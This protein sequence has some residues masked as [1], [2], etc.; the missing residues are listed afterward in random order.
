MNVTLRLPRMTREQFLDWV[1][2]QED[3]YEFDGYEPVPMTG[4][5]RNHSRLCHNLNICLGTRL[6]D[7]PFEVL[8]EGGINTI[9]NAVRYPDVLITGTPGP[10]TDRLM[11][12][13]IV[14][15]EV[16]S[17]TSGRVDRTLKLREYRGV[18]SIRRY[19]IVDNVGPN[20]DVFSRSDA[21]EEWTAV[22]LTSGESLAMP[23]VGLDIPVDEIFRGITFPA[24]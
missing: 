19:V 18:K 22:S 4:G 5:N 12:E 17:P 15:F 7:G 9:G 1:E 3:P 16:I 8:P 20:L 24:A 14:V 13:P 21:E 2:R 11:P 6:L 10:G 23:E